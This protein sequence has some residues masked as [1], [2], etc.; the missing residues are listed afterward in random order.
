MTTKEK[1][2]LAIDMLKNCE[3]WAVQALTAYTHKVNPLETRLS[4]DSVLDHQEQIRKVI[5]QLEQDVD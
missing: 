3:L 2:Q 4:V 5:K 1:I